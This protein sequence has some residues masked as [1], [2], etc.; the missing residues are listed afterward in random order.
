[1]TPRRMF[2]FLMVLALMLAPVAM[3]GS[4]AAAAPHGTVASGMDHC[5]GTEKPTE[6]SA[7]DRVDCMSICSAMAAELPHIAEALIVRPSRPYLPLS[8]DRTGADP[9]ATTPP[10]RRS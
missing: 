6:N 7:A 5:T 10:P 1:M 3:S 2:S 4:A 8:V 9:E